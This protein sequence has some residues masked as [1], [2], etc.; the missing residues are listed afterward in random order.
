MKGM[1]WQINFQVHDMMY[2]MGG[3]ENLFYSGLLN[4]YINIF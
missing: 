1:A 4:K 3:A 2:D